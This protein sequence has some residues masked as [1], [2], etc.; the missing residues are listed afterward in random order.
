M[1][2]AA[3][4]LLYHRSCR[5]IAES[6][7]PTRVRPT[8]PAWLETAPPVYSHGCKS[9]L[10]VAERVAVKPAC[11]TSGRILYFRYS[12]TPDIP[13]KAS[14]HLYS[15][16]APRLLASCYTPPSWPPRISASP[17]PHSRPNGLILATHIA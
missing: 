13:C 12:S 5:M 15:N 8:R 14:D 11:R 2:F 6:G 10:P 16:S 3:P 7:T 4:A 17:E 9:P 1:Y